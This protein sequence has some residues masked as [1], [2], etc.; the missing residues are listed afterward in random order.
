MISRLFQEKTECLLF[1]RFSS[2]DD[3]DIRSFSA[4]QITDDR[5]VDMREF[6]SEVHFNG[7]EG[8]SKV[9]RA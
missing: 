6:V 9:G 4:V 2:I 8:S 3:D 1:K 7:A 5:S